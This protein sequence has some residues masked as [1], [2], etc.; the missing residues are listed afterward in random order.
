MKHFAY[1]MYVHVGSALLSKKSYVLLNNFLTLS[2]AQTF[3]QQFSVSKRVSIQ[4]SEL[5]WRYTVFILR[6]KNG[7]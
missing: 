6:A 2:T 1:Y 3:L 7:R 5:V 4:L